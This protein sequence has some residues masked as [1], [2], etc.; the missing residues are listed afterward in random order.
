MDISLGGNEIFERTG[1]ILTALYQIIDVGG[2]G[3]E[4]ARKMSVDF[5]SHNGEDYGPDLKEFIAKLPQLP[6]Y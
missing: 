1:Q 2:P 4:Q 3:A 6:K 5:I